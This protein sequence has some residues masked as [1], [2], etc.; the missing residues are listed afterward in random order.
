VDK[1]GVMITTGVSSGNSDDVTVAFNRGAGGAVEGQ[2]A[3]SYLLMPEQ[4][5]ALISPSREL[6]FSTLP[7]TGGVLKK[8]TCLHRP[9]LTA[10]N[11]HQIR[12][13]ASEIKHKLKDRA[14]EPFDVEFGFK[15]EK[16]WLFQVRPYVESKRA[17][18][19]TYLHAQDVSIQPGQAVFLDQEI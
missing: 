5:V 15:E 16:I 18:A 11:L 8:E 10:K 4:R 12:E 9:L 17:H 19:S 3:E 2:L 13:L 1:S 7:A 14:Q 6:F